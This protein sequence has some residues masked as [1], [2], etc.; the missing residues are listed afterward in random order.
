MNLEPQSRA[1]RKLGAAARK[2][3]RTLKARGVAS[4]PPAL[5]VTDPVRTPD[6]EII[7]AGLPRGFGVVYRHFGAPG[8]ASVAKRLAAIC[9]PRGVIL[10]IAADPQLAARVGADGVHWPFRLRQNV[11]RWR[12]RFGLQTLSA[13]S[14][15]EL[16]AIAGLPVEAVLVST[17]FASRSPSA[18]SAMGPLRFARLA[19]LSEKPV[20]ALGGITAETA[21]SVSR[22]SGYAAVEGLT[23]F[24]PQIRT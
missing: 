9:R 4:L 22:W 7:A 11:R 17:V 3:G 12:S 6:P 23:A 18:G 2:S 13:H 21:G 19:A 8:H 16:R 5:F 20:Y 15:R 14:G 10:L 24:R 1:R